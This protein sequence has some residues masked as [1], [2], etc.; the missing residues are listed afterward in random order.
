[1]AVWLKT[2][3]SPGSPA[4]L[5][6]GG[7]EVVEESRKINKSKGLGHD[8]LCQ[9]CR[10]FVGTCS[11]DRAEPEP[12]LER[13]WRIKLRIRTFPRPAFGQGPPPFDECAEV[14]DLKLHS[15]LAEL[16]DWVAELPIYD[17]S[18]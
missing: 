6:G 15:T 13:V 8:V 17:G 3:Y 14:I 16:H 1:M 18:G 2:D 4:R 7:L 9:S 5:G 10:A 12:E 11:Y